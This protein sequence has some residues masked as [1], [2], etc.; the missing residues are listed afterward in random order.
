MRECPHQRWSKRVKKL[1][2]SILVC[3]FLFGCEK[4]GQVEFMQVVEDH[5]ELVA[6]TN[7][8]LISSIMDDIASLSLSE[9][10]R[11]GA[12]ELINRLE[13]IRSQSDVMQEYVFTEYADTELLAKLL[14]LKWEGNRNENTKENVP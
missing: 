5:K 3:I 14:K 12:E 8:A 13:M 11:K 10:E 7:A 1:I 2:L 4:R 6:E 9:D